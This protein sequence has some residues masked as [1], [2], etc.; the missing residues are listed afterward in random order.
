[1]ATQEDQPTP[2]PQVVAQVEPERKVELPELL[3]RL[4]FYR[5]TMNCATQRK[6]RCEELMGRQIAKKWSPAKKAQMVRRLMTANQEIQQC[7]AG[8]DETERLVQVIVAEMSQQ[9]LAAA[10]FV[11]EA[12]TSV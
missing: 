2:D 3:Y 4:S 8:I 6:E 9:K 5:H 10:S 11:P 12:P 7:V 1:M